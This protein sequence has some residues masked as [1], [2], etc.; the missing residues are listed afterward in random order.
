MSGLA[1]INPPSSGGGGAVT[2]ADGA[3]VTQGAIADAS[4][5]GDTA[6]TV[7]AKLRGIL[8]ILTDVWSDPNNDLRVDGSAV[9]QPVSQFGAWTTGRTWVLGSGTDSV[10]VVGTITANQGGAPWSFTDASLDNATLVDN[11]VFTDGTTRV[12][13]SGYIF[14]EVVGT[15]LTENDAAAARVDS[16]RAQVLVLEDA[17]TRGQ[18]QTVK[19]ASTAAVAADLPAVVALHP[20]TALPEMRAATLGVTATAA[21]N[22]G[23]TLTLP[24][25]GAGLFHYIVSLE[26]VK[27]YSIVG[28]A[29]GA[30]VI[31]TSTNMPGTPAWTTEQLASVAGTTAR[32]IKEEPTTPLKSSVANTATTF[33]APAQLQTI[34]RWNV[35]YFTAT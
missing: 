5:T 15:A 3:D 8:K 32:V 12:M 33:V 30:G 10:T 4:V 27:L 26:L 2:I 28:V 23:S 17:T 13:M 29:A 6:G 18:R 14:D 21:V 1:Q 34:W 22:T 7:S 24:A 31:I 16:K 9:V 11:N 20:T 19:A 35:R 25:A